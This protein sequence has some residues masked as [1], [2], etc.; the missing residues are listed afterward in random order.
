MSY[1]GQ[2]ADIPMNGGLTGTKHQSQILP[3]KLKQASNVSYA[4]GS[5]SKENGLEE[6]FDP[7]LADIAFNTEL[8]IGGWDW[9]PDATNQYIMSVETDGE[10]RRMGNNGLPNTVMAS[11]LTVTNVVPVFVEG[12][13]EV[14]ANNRKLFL[15]TGVNTVRV[16]SGSAT[17]ATVLATPP[18]DWSG[19]NQPSTGAIHEAR[20]WGAGNANDPHRVY[21]STT[22]SH[23]DFT[24]AGS[25][26]LSVYPGEGQ[27]IVQIMSF[28]GL[29]VV[30]KYPRG[31]YYVDTTDPTVGN[32]KIKRL[33]LGTGG[34]SPLGA[35]PVDDDVM[36]IDAQGNIHLLSTVQEF[37]N[38]QANNI[39]RIDYINIFLKEN[40]NLSLLRQTQGVYYAHKREAH[41]IMAAIGSTTLN[42]RLVCDFNAELPR[43]EFSSRV[44]P[45]I[46]LRI[47][48]EGI[49]RPTISHAG[50]TSGFFR[51]YYLDNP[52]DKSH[53]S[54]FQTAP[55]DLSH[56]DP[57]LAVK[58][59]NGH[60]L[61]ILAEPKGNWQLHVDVLWDGVVAETVVF[62][63]SAL[64][65]A[66]DSFV[67]DS[68]VL[69]SD[70]LENI[71]HRITGSG[72]RFSVIAR[73]LTEEDFSISNM[74][75]Y[76]SIADERN[77]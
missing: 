43:F 15:F 3:N 60:F 25:G 66:L 16:T 14:A 46:W 37:G 9:W 61:E 13:K 8:A 54:L 4:D 72:K 5:L 33:T 62:T 63:G 51:F 77:L 30:W 17:P 49:Q 20:L 57:G 19:T 42:R 50:L 56:V 34:V 76:Y 36:F 35:V 11:G 47:D 29:L 73:C 6:V 74:L 1:K 48:S 69:G 26:S 18:A 38:M 71:K 2:I 23:E 58:R 55:I 59:K 28:K 75:L 41:F 22:T 32:W 45:G 53:F 31:I 52:D 65:G 21:Y 27:K 44:N 40:I 24:G 39:S 70:Q 12:G 68:D 7:I 67:L 64:G 10:F